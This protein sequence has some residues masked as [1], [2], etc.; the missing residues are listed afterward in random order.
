M[1]MDSLCYRAKDPTAPETTVEGAAYPVSLPLTGHVVG[2]QDADLVAGADLAG[3]H[4]AEGQEAALIR[5]GNHLGH[6]HHQGTV[7]VAVAD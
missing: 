5:G 4:T 3:E 2:A 7:G 1:G 6:V